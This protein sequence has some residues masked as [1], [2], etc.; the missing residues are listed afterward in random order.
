MFGTGEVPRAPNPLEELGELVREA[1]P[2]ARA[3]R[4]PPG[5]QSDEEPEPVPAAY[6][7]V[8]LLRRKD[9]ADMT[10]EELA[11]ANR[12]LA[13]LALRGPTRARGG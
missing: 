1:L 3:A 6:S 10:D 5:A 8:E 12:I 9:F 2:E 7:D 11:A 13:R 4:E